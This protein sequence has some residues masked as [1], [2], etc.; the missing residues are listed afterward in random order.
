MHMSQPADPEP[1]GDW[2]SK[3]DDAEQT[4]NRTEILNQFF[5]GMLLLNGGACV[6]LLAFL[7]AIW[8]KTTTDFVRMVIFGMA[9]LL[10]GLVSTAVSQY[11]RYKISLHLQYKRRKKGR[12]W[13]RAYVSLVVLSVLAFVAGVGVILWGLYPFSE[14]VGQPARLSRA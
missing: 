12:R 8:D 4:R 9:P 5:R 13:Q 10:L 2:T 6:A 11:A 14:L 3:L 1:T 7:Q